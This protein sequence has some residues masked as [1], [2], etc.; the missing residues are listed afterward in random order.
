MIKNFQKY[1]SEIRGGKNI[2]PIVFEYILDLLL[3]PA[4]LLNLNSQEILYANKHAASLFDIEQLSIKNQRVSD[5]FKDIDFINDTFMQ[6]IFDIER[7]NEQVVSALSTYYHF[8]SSQDLGV[9]IIEPV[10]GNIGEPENHQKES[11]FVIEELFKLVSCFDIKKQ[12]N[13]FESILNILKNILK[14]RSITIYLASSD[15]PTFNKSYTN[16]FSNWLP[17]NLTHQDISELN[18]TRI[19][20]AGNRI[21][22][23]IHT[24]AFNNSIAKLISSPLGQTNAMI[25]LVVVEDFH[26]ENDGDLLT[27]MNLSCSIISTVIQ[28]Q[29]REHELLGIIGAVEAENVI[30]GQIEQ[31]IRDGLVLLDGNLEILRVNNATEKIFGY[32]NLEAQ[33]Q[34]IDQ[35]VI[36]RENL[37]SLLRNLI[38]L[39]AIQEFDD[40][41]L[42]RRSGESFPAQIRVKTI[43]HKNNQLIYLLLITDL[44]D[45]EQ[46]QEHT[47][48][49]EQRAFLGEVS[50]IFAH[51]VRNP[52]NNIS[53]GL[54]L[55]ALNL[56]Q[57]DENQD[58]IT[59]LQNDCDRLEVLIKSIL[60]YSK[61]GEY[62]MVKIDILLLINRILNQ[63]QP[64]I[65][66]LNI[67]SQ[68]QAE[69]NLPSISGNFRALEQVF[70]NIID[71]AIQAMKPTGGQLSIK[72]N[73]ISE[74]GVRNYVLVGIAD[75]GPGIPDDEIEHIFHPFYTTKRAGTGLGL[76]ISK[77]IITA[78]RGNIYVESF[79]GGTIFQVEIP[80]FK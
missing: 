24:N 32:T 59:R 7:G 66:R 9:V 71:N 14:A 58:I 69:K 5:I 70:T 40:Y 51:E 23:P 11:S 76:A 38:P 54:E 37:I 39:Q 22:S 78:H 26:H 79:P 21:R 8:P 20:E 6:F 30:A 74:G 31:T 57:T 48:D 72:I 80:I 18:K 28:I 56:P 55:M 3:Q 52:I 65:T 4:I 43:K 25:G 60:N 1:V 75:T 27:L 36:G 34:P 16:G 12:D 73:N 63:L 67:E 19:W 15:S 10:D 77:R 64:R 50:S 2:N 33:G 46:I 13:F 35:V 17:D 44:S 29:S 68:V 47:R 53:T 41:R 62:T 49:L 61:P 42:Y 45:Q